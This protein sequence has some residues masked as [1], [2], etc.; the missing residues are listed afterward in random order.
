[1]ETLVHHR[2]PSIEKGHEAGAVPGHEDSM[3][4]DGL[5][6]NPPG[7]RRFNS[8]AKLKQTLCSLSSSRRD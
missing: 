3:M 6:K 8:H 5:G 7:P 1:M 4:V 2:T